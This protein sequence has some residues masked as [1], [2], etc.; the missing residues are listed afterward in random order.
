MLQPAAARAQGGEVQTVWRLL[1]YVAVDYAGAVS[2]SRVTSTTEYAEMTEFSATIRTGIAALP[3]N[4]GRARLIAEAQGLE[5]AIASK[6]APEAVAQTA[7][8]LASDLLR[9]EERRV[10]NAC[11]STCKTRW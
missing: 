10:R 11:V 3:S 6:A 1:D 8:A 4:P 5:A 2:G 9:S 7:R